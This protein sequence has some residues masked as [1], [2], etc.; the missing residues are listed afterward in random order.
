MKTKKIRGLNQ[1]WKN[2][3]KWKNAQ[4]KLNIENLKQYERDYAKIWVHP[5]SGISITNSKKTEPKRETKKRILN[6]LIDIYE[7]WKNQLDELNEPY[8]LKIWLFEERLSKSQVVCAIGNSIDY[9]NST[10]NIPENTK[11]FKTDF[12]GLIKT[13]MESFNWEHRLDE[14]ILFS[15]DI[16]D[17]E[18]YKN[19]IEYLENKKWLDNRLKKKHVI[20]IL[21][22]GTESY[23]F[24][25]GKVWIGEKK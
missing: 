17:R 24:E 8:Y 15:S 9:Y 4:L 11:K 6:G 5:F 20:K 22:D 19:E 2:I 18:D 10:F 3:E 21:K 13:R 16:G 23:A 7:S 12:I 1:I 14:N 25:I